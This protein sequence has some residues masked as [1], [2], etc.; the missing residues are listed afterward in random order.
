MS[1]PRAAARALGCV[2]A[3]VVPLA[4]CGKSSEPG[5]GTTATATAPSPSASSSEVHSTPLDAAAA[6]SSA[7][8]VASLAA[9]SSASSA[10]SSPGSPPSSSVSAGPAL[11]RCTADA[12]CVPKTCCHATECT[13]RTKAPKCVGKKCSKKK[14]DLSFDW[15]GRCGCV[16]GVCQAF[17]VRAPRSLRHAPKDPF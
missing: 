2:F 14:V 8:S 7:A 12:D 10:A 4:A 9:S 3:V 16:D 13:L 17:L 5:A 11:D 1:G 6:A 15:G